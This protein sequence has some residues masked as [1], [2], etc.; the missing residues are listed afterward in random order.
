MHL[1]RMPGVVD[2]FEAIKSRKH[3]D[4]FLAAQIAQ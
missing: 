4:A 2:L 1:N 3:S